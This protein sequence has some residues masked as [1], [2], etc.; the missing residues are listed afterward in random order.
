MTISVQPA[1]KEI[2]PDPA[3]VVKALSDE[4]KQF[5]SSTVTTQDKVLYTFRSLHLQLKI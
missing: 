3:E 4:D 1:S 2:S 5:F